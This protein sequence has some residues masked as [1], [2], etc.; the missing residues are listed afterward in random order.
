MTVVDGRTW[1]EHLSTESCWELL[2][3]TP[4]GRVVVMVDG[5][6]E[7]YPVNFAVDDRSVAFRTAPGSKLRGLERFPTTCFEADV[8]DPDDRSGWSVMLKGRAVD[9]VHADDVQRLG[10]LPLTLWTAGTKDHWVRIRPSEVTGRRIH[11]IRDRNG[12][13]THEES[14]G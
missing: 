7:V 6:P 2:R 12:S 4:V 9:V 8:I 5:A 10:A 14:Q 3:T 11:T 1:M 13:G